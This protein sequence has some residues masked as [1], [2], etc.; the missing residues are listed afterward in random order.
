MQERRRN[1]GGR[2]RQA[3]ASDVSEEQDADE[4]AS[5]RF[6]SGQPLTAGLLVWTTS[7]PLV[8]Q[9][10]CFRLQL[11]GWPAFVGAAVLSSRWF[12]SN[13]LD[14]FT[15]GQLHLLSMLLTCRCC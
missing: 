5:G 3:A 2:R 11:C 7:L 6:Q 8:Q 15:K 4:S 9:Q 10:S 14:A 1:G 12:E 13:N